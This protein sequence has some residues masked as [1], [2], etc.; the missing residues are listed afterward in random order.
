VGKDADLEIGRI[1]A[2]ASNSAYQGTTE[3][4]LGQVLAT[5]GKYF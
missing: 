3:K 4:G 1:L 5:F 2:E